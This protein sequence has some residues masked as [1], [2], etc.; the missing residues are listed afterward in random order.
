MAE[1]CP[2]VKSCA[3]A[4][5]TAGKMSALHGELTWGVEGPPFSSP[6]QLLGFIQE[7]CWGGGVSLTWRS[8]EAA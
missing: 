6:L 3:R 5:S 2:L 1:H 8:L 7:S 4:Q